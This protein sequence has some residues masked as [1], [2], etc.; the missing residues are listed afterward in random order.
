MQSISKRLIS[1]YLLIGVFMLVILESLFIFAIA[2]YYLGGIELAIW[3]TMPICPLLFT[4]SMSL[5]MSKAIK[6]PFRINPNL[7][8]KI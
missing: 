8:L 7:F 2:Q 4:V 6:S 1:N 3:S 5:R